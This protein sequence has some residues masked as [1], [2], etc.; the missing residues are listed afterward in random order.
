MVSKRTAFISVLG[1]IY[2]FAVREETD[3]QIEEQK[4]QNSTG[5]EKE[6]HAVKA[7]LG[8]Q[9]D[10][11]QICEYSNLPELGFGSYSCNPLTSFHQNA[12]CAFRCFGSTDFIPVKCQCLI[13]HGIFWTPD[14]AGCHWLFDEDGFCDFQEQFFPPQI[15]LKSAAEDETVKEI[16]GDL[17][18]QAET[19]EEVNTE[20]MTELKQVEFEN[21]FANAMVIQNMKK[22][23]DEQVMSNLQFMKS[24]EERLEVYEHQQ[25]IP[26]RHMESEVRGIRQMLKSDRLPMNQVVDLDALEVYIRQEVLKAILHLTPTNNHNNSPK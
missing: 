10:P 13:N 14:P 19:I 8:L 12:E 16:I 7:V 25:K 9:I 21:S 24:M 17:H 6:N 23:Q 4:S 3:F 1:C 18:R 2:C 15:R 22:Y 5:L 26:I 20:I 11:N